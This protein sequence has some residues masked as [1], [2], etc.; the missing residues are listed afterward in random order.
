MREQS[1]YA[2]PPAQFTKADGTPYRVYTPFA[3]AL[4]KQLALT[5]PLLAPTQLPPLPPTLAHGELRDLA[6]LPTKSWDAGLRNAWQPGEAGAQ[7]ALDTFIDTH[8]NNYAAARDI[9]ARP[10]TSRLSPHLHFG[11]ISVQ[12]I[13]WRLQDSSGMALEQHDY[14]QLILDLDQERNAALAAYRS[15]TGPRKRIETTRGT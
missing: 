7:R 9:P 11:E 5:P 13:A 10:G 12:Q 1:V 14:P 2:P 4:L 15:I 6:L 3:A 8:M